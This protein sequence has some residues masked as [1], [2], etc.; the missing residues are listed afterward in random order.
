MIGIDPGHGG[1]NRGTKSL[2]IDEADYTLD[3]ADRLASVLYAHGI[4]SKLSRQTDVGMRFVT[5]AEK[6]RECN[7]VIV[8]HANANSDNRRHGMEFYHNPKDTVA[9]CAATTMARCV[10]ERL[11]KGRQVFDVG[12]D[13]DDPSDDW[14]ERPENTIERY[15]AKMI[16]SV[17]VE[18]GYGTNDKD[19][20]FMLSDW[21]KR[22]IC[23]T[24]VAGIIR[25][26]D[27]MEKIGQSWKH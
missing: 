22:S 5:R 6:L 13:P 20:K 4:E 2:G 24:I 23:N 3:I 17:L 10:S 7:F 11:N 27:F 19:R 16:P 25:A 18:I 26:N 15:W 1:R 12:N 9:F 14:L 21:G 8:L